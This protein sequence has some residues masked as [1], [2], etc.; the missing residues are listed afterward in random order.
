MEA[1]MKQ[2]FCLFAVLFLLAGC[3][4][5]TSKPEEEETVRSI[6]IMTW[7]VNNLFDGKDDGFEYAEFKSSS[8]WSHEKYMGRINAI[9]AAIDSLDTAPDI[10][11]LQEVESLK[12]LED[13]AFSLPKK[14]VWNHFANNYGSAVG[15]G[16]LSRLPLEESRV[17]S[18]TMNGE[19]T[20]RPVLEARIQTEAG[21][22][23]IFVCHWKSKLG[24]D[25]ITENVRKASVR[26]IL[27]R[28]AEIWENEPD[29]G[30]IVAGDLNENHN[31][32]YR[33]N[34]KLICALLP[35]EPYCAQIAGLQKDFIVIAKNKPPEPVYFPQDTVILFSPWTDDLEK[36]SY[37]YA[38]NWETI[39]HFLL[40]GQFF[41]YAGWEYESA[42][43]INF[44]PFANA[45][46]IP[47]GYNVKTGAGL[48]DHFPLLLT[49][50]KVYN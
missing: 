17:H 23:V 45:N 6:V 12:V 20:P 27:R 50:K 33:Q 48:S 41:D 35:D 43:V 36:G 24:G 14:Y 28:M 25:E 22:F 13:L 49:L 40:S 37:Y 30:V 21:A 4:Y 44:P 9:S 7:N 31:E 47:F 26:I 1:V 46:G 11:L 16:I 19:T 29:L 3:S 34:S 15:L 38:Y 39:D 42:S 18:I 32:F 10:I 5:F 2:L 8:S